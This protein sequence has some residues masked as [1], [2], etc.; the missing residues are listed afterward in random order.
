MRKRDGNETEMRHLVIS[1][2]PSQHLDI[3]LDIRMAV[4]ILLGNENVCVSVMIIRHTA[5]RQ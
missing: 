5:E 1:E 2:F 3:P 4:W